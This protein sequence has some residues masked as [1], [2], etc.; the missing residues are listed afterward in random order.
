MIATGLTEMRG[1]TA[2]RLHLELM[3][4]RVLL[5]GADADERGLHARMDRLERRVGMMGDAEASSVTD[6]QDTGVQ[7]KPK[8]ERPSAVEVE[9]QRPAPVTDQPP[10]AA[11]SRPEQPAQRRA[12]GEAPR[13]R[14]AQQAPA[15]EQPQQR[16]APEQRPAAPQPPAAPAPVQPRAQLTAAELRRVWPNVLE[17]VKRRRRFT[18]MLLSNHA[19]VLEVADGALTLGFDAQGPKENFASGVGS[20]DVLSDALIEVIGVELRIVAVLAG[21]EQ[22]ARPAQRPQG[23]PAVEPE[24]ERR[25]QPQEERPAQQPPSEQVSADDAVLDAAHNA[26]ELLSS[27]FGAEV[28]SVRGADE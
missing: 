13:Q 9:R 15:P 27:T 22:A 26:E 7:R 20:A 11:E 24:P 1:T 3:C 10:P 8:P 25:A 18:F 21:G 12:P 5:P 23:A 19:Q 14:P 17:E 4:S 2:P 28:I 6:W 16:P